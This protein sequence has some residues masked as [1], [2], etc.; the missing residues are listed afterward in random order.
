MTLVFYTYSCEHRSRF[1]NS[2]SG[3]FSDKANKRLFILNESQRWG[4]M[5]KSI[6]RTSNPLFSVNVVANDSK[7]PKVSNLG[8]LK[9]SGNETSYSFLHVLLICNSAD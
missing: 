5:C 4:T 7:Q 2:R 9:R 1:S 3:V 8:D 6:C